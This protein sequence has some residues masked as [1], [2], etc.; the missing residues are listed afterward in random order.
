MSHDPQDPQRPD[1]PVTPQGGEPAPSEDELVRLAVPARVR[2]APK[3]GV[4]IV[5]GALVG[6]VVGLL[7]TLFLGAGSDG[8]G[9]SDV[10]SGTGFISFLDGQGSIRLVMGTA[11]AVVGGFVGGALAVRADRRSRDPLG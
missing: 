2:R 8:T 3:Y 11:G 1:E 6:V 9:S 4:F 10:A 5:A 7:L